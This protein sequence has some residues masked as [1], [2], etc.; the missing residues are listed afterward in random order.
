MNVPRFSTLA[1]VV[2]VG[3]L[4]AGAPCFGAKAPA[5]RPDWPVA[6]VRATSLVN[7]PTITPAPAESLLRRVL[8]LHAYED[9]DPSSPRSSITTY[10]V[11]VVNPF[12]LAEDDPSGLRVQLELEQ[13]YFGRVLDPKTEVTNFWA[14]GII[15]TM[16]SKDLWS[17][18]VEWRATVTGMDLDAPLVVVAEGQAT[19]N[20]QSLD[21]R[22][23]LLT[24]NHRAFYKLAF[25]LATQLANRRKVPLKQAFVNGDPRDYVRTADSW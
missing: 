6:A 13:C 15:G 3:G 16:L 20:V 11:R 25:L 14:L 18:M 5:E 9:A 4:V 24:A 22:T 12:R 17:G 10:D 1:V 2:V 19:G 23:A 7:D 8:T 21:R